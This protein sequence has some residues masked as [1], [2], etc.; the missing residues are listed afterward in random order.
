[1]AIGVSLTVLLLGAVLGVWYLMSSH[2]SKL[3][4]SMETASLSAATERLYEFQ[5]MSQTADVTGVYEDHP[6]VTNVCNALSEYNEDSLLFIYVTVKDGNSYTDTH[7]YTYNGVSLNSTSLSSFPGHSSATQLYSGTE[8]PVTYAVKQLL[9][10]S[11]YRCHVELGNYNST[12]TY[13]VV[14]VLLN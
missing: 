13:I 7:Y 4:A 9:T 5:D 3:Q 1:M 2:E 14:E 10:Y 11:Q 8:I 12:Y 6:L